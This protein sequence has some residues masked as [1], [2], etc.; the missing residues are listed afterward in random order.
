M[1][2]HSILKKLNKNQKG[3][4][5]AELLI[6]IA[7][8]G[9]ITGGIT[10]SIF[11]VFDGNIRSTNHMTAV[12]QVQ[13]AGYWISRDVQMAQSVDDNPA[14]PKI[15]ELAWV[16]WEYECDSPNTCINTYEVHYTHDSDSN[17]LWRYQ[18][19]ATD[20]YDANGQYLKTTYTPSEGWDTTPIAQH[21]TSI[22][23]PSMAGNKLT[24]TVTASV[25][26]AEEERT[27]EV[28]PRPDS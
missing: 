5:L 8:T 15:L 25:G 12:R 7:I 21:I 11:Q 17:K 1:K 13:N 28:V 24:V 27:Y 6:A 4:A 22:S 20:K 19:I 2:K 9:L 16:G 3:Y 26:E 23:I 18:K 10:T 14:A